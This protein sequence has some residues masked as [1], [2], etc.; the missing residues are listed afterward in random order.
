VWER[1]QVGERPVRTEVRNEAGSVAC[2]EAV[3]GEAVLFNQTPAHAMHKK[4]LMPPVQACMSQ[5]V[6]SNT[7]LHSVAGRRMGKMG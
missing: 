7:R 4:C 2:H 3:A 1:R 6:V 5:T